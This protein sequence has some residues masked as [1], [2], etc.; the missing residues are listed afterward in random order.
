M[1]KVNLLIVHY[2]APP[3]VGGVEAVIQAHAK[4]FI[5]G[6]FR[7]V[8]AAGVGREQ[9]LAP[10]VNLTLIP[11]MDS[12]HPEI[13]RASLE[14]EEGGIPGNFMKLSTKLEDELR[15]L[16]QAAEAVIVHN[17]FTKHFNLPLSAALVRML[18]QGEIQRCIAWCHDFSWTSSHSRSKVHPGFPWD[19]LRTYRQ[20]V[21]Y[22][23][24]SHHRRKELARL[25]RCPPD[26]IRVIYNGVEPRVLLGLTAEGEALAARLGL[27]DC[28]LNLLMPVRI[29]QAKNI[30]YA[31]DVVARIKRRGI[32][33]KLV[34]TGPP[35]PHDDQNMAYYEDLLKLRKQANVEDEMRFVYESGD[36]PRVPLTIDL[37][38][39]ADLYKAC[40]FLFMPSH[41]E[42]YGMPIVEAGLAGMPVISAK[43]PAAQEI[44]GEDIYTIDPDDPAEKTAEQ[45]ITWWH[46]T[47]TLRLR[48]RVRREL[49]WQAIFNRQILPLLRQGGAT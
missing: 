3:V 25:F 47:P 20:D 31:I 37:R 38:V 45:I 6:N 30:E 17:A 18:D 29:T 24:V 12:R 39:V 22:V 7:V 32:R 33:V 5:E 40:D 4:L 34:V 11:E 36:D 15:P 48:R 43:F 28:D 13:E 21:T 16:A 23:T 49:T 19:L 9:D 8:V 26:L 46:E 42:G 10:G 41:R 14:L 35:D 27:W 1:D 44:G 2:S